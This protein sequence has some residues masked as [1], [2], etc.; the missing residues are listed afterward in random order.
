MKRFRLILGILIFTA[1]ASATWYIARGRLNPAPRIASEVDAPSS[2]HSTLEITYIANQGVLISVGDKQVLID[3]LHR[4]YKPAYA[5]L[6]PPQ[7]EKIETAK[8]PFDTIDLILVSHLHL[9]HFHPESVGRHLQH[10]LEATLVSSQ[11][12]T[13]EVEKN[14]KGYDAIKTR[15]VAATPPLKERVAMKA[16]G[17]DFEV[18][19]LRHGNEN[20]RWI[21]NLGHLI[22]LGG[23]R[24]LHIGDAD[25]ALENFESFKLHEAG[26]DVAFIPF[27]FLLD[28]DGQTLVTKHIRPKHII[29]VHISPDDAEKVA[30]QIKQNF[31]N[32][33]AFTT[34][35]EKRRY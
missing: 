5:F 19:G 10:N 28:E 15:V 21:Q 23:K 22:K 3:G 13:D 29:A 14:F 9:D 24:I 6:P 31:P 16:S 32:A 30:G 2:Q 7:R 8:A 27:W 17:I 34:M 11:Q 25:T 12:V 33:V 18:L 1:V 4:E 20:F 26:I 35:L